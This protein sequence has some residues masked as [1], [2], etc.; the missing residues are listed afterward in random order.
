MPSL[1]LQKVFILFLFDKQLIS[2]VSYFNSFFTFSLLFLCCFPG[3]TSKIFS[4]WPSFSS[5]TRHLFLFFSSSSS[6]YFKFG[7]VNY[8]SY[9]FFYTNFLLEETVNYLVAQKYIKIAGKSTACKSYDY[10]FYY[11]FIYYYHLFSI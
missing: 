11:H 3:K 8:S 5:K 6:F 7:L 4:E 1:L 9:D 10:C 2:N